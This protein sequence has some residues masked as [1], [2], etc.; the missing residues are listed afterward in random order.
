MKIIQILYLLL[1]FVVVGC[2]K[3]EKIAQYD[4]NIGSE[5]V[6]MDITPYDIRSMEDKAIKKIMPLWD[7]LKEGE[8]VWYS[9]SVTRPWA[10]FSDET[11]KGEV[12][13]TST[14]GS[15]DWRFFKNRDGLSGIENRT[16]PLSTSE[17]MDRSMVVELL[18]SDLR[19]FE[20]ILRK[21]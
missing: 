20:P 18:R 13:A 16:N 5:I 7:Q 6:K 3:R 9:Y 15:G 1:T 11:S 10:E 12:L 21:N 14:T 17:N 8:S 19:K 4:L 2:S